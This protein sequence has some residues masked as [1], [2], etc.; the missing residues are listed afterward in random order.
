MAAMVTMGD[1]VCEAAA[2]WDDRCRAFLEVPSSE[3]YFLGREKMHSTPS[4]FGKSAGVQF[5]VTDVQP[6]FGA[7]AIDGQTNTCGKK[8]KGSPEQGKNKC[9][10]TRE[11]HSYIFQAVPSINC[12]TIPCG[13]SLC[14]A[15]NSEMPAP[16]AK[17]IVV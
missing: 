14:F 2:G 1:A 3:I 7:I 9:T 8:K 16:G 5:P 15:L 6:A 13:M 4:F 10:K 11:Y 17:P 12:E